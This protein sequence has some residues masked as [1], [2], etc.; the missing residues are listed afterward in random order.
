MASLLVVGGGVLGTLHSYLAISAGL[1]VTH[2][3]RTMVPAAASVRNFGLIWVSGRRAGA[4]LKLALRARQIWG[5]IGLKIPD[6]GFRAHGSLTV[7]QNEAELHVTELA[8]K[9][10]D[11]DIRGFEF[12]NGVDLLKLE[13][14]LGKKV[15][16]ALRCNQDA[17][18]EPGTVLTAIRE[19]LLKTTTLYKWKPNSEVV[20]FKSSSDSFYIRTATGE[21]LT[22]DYIVIVPGADHQGVFREFFDGASIRRVRLYMG[23]TES[24]NYRLKHSIANADS[25]R[26]YPAFANCDLKSLKAQ[27]SIAAAFNMQLLLSQR[28]DGTFTIGDT[29]QYEEP[30]PFEIEEAPFTYLIKEINN[31]F[32]SSTKIVRRWDGIYSQTTNNEIYY[33]NRIKTNV[34]VI[35]GL[36]G[37]GNTLSPA[38][39]EET[40]KSFAII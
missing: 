25:Y 16:G 22:A 5:E 29:H 28:L 40:L 17:I 1:Q 37:R 36:G 11:A 32:D 6:T 14:N 10:D 35:S 20:D 23:A 24:V 9:M 38:I 8:A 31:I 30:F 4:E 18:V 3:E 19:Y 26:Y 39:A 21:K 34:H 12:I 7:A 13:P 15:L 2:L 27:D 33:R